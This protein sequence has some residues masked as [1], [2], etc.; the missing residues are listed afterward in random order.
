MLQGEFGRTLETLP[1]QISRAALPLGIAIIGIAIIVFVIVLIW[2]L[3]FQDNSDYAKCA[4]TAGKPHSYIEHCT[5]AID[6]GDLSIENLADAFNYRGVAYGH[7]GD[8]DRAI[9]D[10][11][12]AIRLDPEYADA[13]FNRGNAY[14]DK[15]DYDRAIQDYDQ[16]I[17]LDPD[18]PLAFF[19]RG[20]RYRIEGDYDRAI[21]DYD[22]AIRIART[23]SMPS[24]T[25]ASRT[26]TRASTTAPSSTTIRRSCSTRTMLMRTTISPGSWPRHRM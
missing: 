26:I 3:A 24:T 13:F 20:N 19:N 9:R 14:D 4:E 8:Y 17:R 23:M 16:A 7:K 22:Q 12:E 25:G 21:H 10:Y 5:R 11:D 2:I 1:S 6:S 18:F 15:G